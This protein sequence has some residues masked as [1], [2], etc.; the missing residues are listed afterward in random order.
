VDE[1]TKNISNYNRAI[2]YIPVQYVDRLTSN[3]A[4]KSVVGDDRWQRPAIS[5]VLVLFVRRNANVSSTLTHL[6]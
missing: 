5:G 3:E 2:F 6:A 1:A 4:F